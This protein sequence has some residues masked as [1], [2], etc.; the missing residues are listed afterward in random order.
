MFRWLVQWTFNEWCFIKVIAHSK[1]NSD[2]F[3]TFLLDSL[4]ND[5]G[6]AWLVM[7]NASLHKTD[8]VRNLVDQSRQLNF[9]TTLFSYNESYR[10][11]VFKSETIRPKY[12]SRSWK[13]STF[14]RNN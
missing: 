6:E 3:V 7:D 11:N 14:N 5:I 8:K 1:V 4:E 10:R 2:I 12:S 9:P 13:A